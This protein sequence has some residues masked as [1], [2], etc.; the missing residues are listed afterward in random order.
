MIFESLVI[1]VVV[2]GT[3]H[4]QLTEGDLEQIRSVQATVG[5]RWLRASALCSQWCVLQ[6]LGWVSSD[7]WIMFAKARLVQAIKNLPEKEDALHVLRARVADVGRGD[8]RGLIAEVKEMYQRTS[9]PDAWCDMSK[10][11]G[12]HWKK[13]CKTAAFTAMDAKCQA[14]LSDHVEKSGDF[15]HLLP[16]LQRNKGPAWH[17]RNGSQREAGLMTSARCGAW[18]VAGGKS[19]ANKGSLKSMVCPLCLGGGVDSVSHILMQCAWKPLEEG[20]EQMMREVS[21][22]MSDLDRPKWENLSIDDAR[23]ALLG[24]R[25]GP[26]DTM[27][28]RLLRDS[29]V[30]KFMVMAN[31][32]RMKAG[33]R[34]LC[35]PVG[36]PPAFSLE[37][38]MQWAREDP[39]GEW[40]QDGSHPK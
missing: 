34:N 4:T 10:R 8:K 14:W 20:R 6:E 28:N 16:E 22:S 11:K 2:A 26:T 19:G 1:S 40:D 7:G 25:M 3:T 9:T 29:A 35:G 38:A 12:V 37:E 39:G 33:M 36:G 23:R 21:E 17:I 24:K 5:R 18:E 30:K 31:D 13:V 27:K 15:V 32:Q